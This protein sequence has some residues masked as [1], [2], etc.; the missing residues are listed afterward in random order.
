MYQY[1]NA[2]IYILLGL[3]GGT[4]HYLKKK[5]VDKTTDDSFVQYL[6]GNF[7]HTLYSI[8]AIAFSEINLSL[9]Q[10]GDVIALG[11]LVGALTMG[12]SM[13]STVNKASD[14]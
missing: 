5:Y 9:L 12:Y 10:A 14:A 4:A 8:G 1:T 6:T 2:L 3:M 13:D 11:E 7:P